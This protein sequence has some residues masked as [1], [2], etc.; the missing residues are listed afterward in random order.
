MTKE[1]LV[2][3]IFEELNEKWDNI[4]SKNE[5]SFMGAKQDIIHALNDN[6]EICLKHSHKHNCITLIIHYKWKTE[7]SIKISQKLYLK[8]ENNIIKNYDEELFK[9]IYHIKKLKET[10]VNK[11]FIA[12]KKGD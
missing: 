11:N 10:D 3:L 4:E 6:L 5:I 1:K 12:R 7:I 8:I 9:M 2:T